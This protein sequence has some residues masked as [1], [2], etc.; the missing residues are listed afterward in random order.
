[1]AGLLAAPWLACHIAGAQTK[2]QTDAAKSTSPA[3][4]IIK[5]QVRQVLFDVVVTD[6]KNR[7][8]PGLTREDF[9]VTEDGALQ[10]I[11][12]FEAHISAGEPAVRADPP[13]DFSK[14]PANTFLNLS[15]AREDLPLNVIL[16]DVLNTPISD[17][18]FAR[19]DIRKF[20]LNKPPGSR[21]AI[22]VLSDKLHLLQGVTDS[23]EELLAAM[24]SRAAAPQPTAQGVPNTPTLSASTALADSGLIPNFAGPQ[25]MLARLK[26]LEGL[27]DIY[28][29][30]R[31]FGVTV[32]AFDEI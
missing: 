16:Y 18:Y 5:A 2:L 24:D 31:R 9:S 3:Q 20:L 30:Q 28:F 17:Q 6:G 19:R 27:G 26:H 4:T 14:L 23:Q 8:V 12:S 29:L 21:Y 32:D 22:F 7:P 13:L 25:E 11:L 1:M 15:R 10:Q